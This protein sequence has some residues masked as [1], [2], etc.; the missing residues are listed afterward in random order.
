MMDHRASVRSLALLAVVLAVTWPLG[1]QATFFRP[2]VRTIT[3]M[4]GPA[5]LETAAAA[6]HYCLYFGDERTAAID[7]ETGRAR[8]QRTL[9]LVH[10]VVEAVPWTQPAAPDRWYLVLRGGFGGAPVCRLLVEEAW[11]NVPAPARHVL[12]ALGLDDPD[13]LLVSWQLVS[14]SM[15]VYYHPRFDRDLE[16]YRGRLAAMERYIA[17]HDLGEELPLG[18]VVHLDTGAL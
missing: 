1:A 6:P 15:S 18:N 4:V 16:F 9:M 12:A 8:A 2:T 14:G 3:A 7:E 10:P 5:S 17:T 13:L 11:R